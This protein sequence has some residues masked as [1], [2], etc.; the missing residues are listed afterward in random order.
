LAADMADAA[1]AEREQKRD[2]HFIL[3][4]NRVSGVL[5]LAALVATVVTV[6][7]VFPVRHNEL[8]TQ[9]IAAHRGEGAW[10][11][12]GPTEIELRAWSTGS[13]GTAVPWPVPGPGIE[14]VGARSIEI[15]KQ[16]T[17]LVRYRIDGDVV[18][19]IAQRTRET[20]PRV[21]RRVDGAMFAISWH[22]GK[23]TLVAVGPEPSATA[24]RP[25]VG[26]P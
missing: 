24:W 22:S 1:D 25:K 20:T 18:T 6:Y 13:L 9:S 3:R 21:H 10:D 5:A 16:R 17:G 23:W 2:P 14:V 26:A 7:V 12:E 11:I 19:V 4:S 15:Q 8:I